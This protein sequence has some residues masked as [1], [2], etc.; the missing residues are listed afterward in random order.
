MI[1]DRNTGPT[2]MTETGK[3]KT[4]F[5]PSPTAPPP[6]PPPERKTLKRKKKKTYLIKA[7]REKYVVARARAR[8]CELFGPRGSEFMAHILY[9]GRLY[10]IRAC[11]YI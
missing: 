10:Y 6:P 9:T 5:E 2:V 4:F 8:V 7:L 11:V 3:V 1:H